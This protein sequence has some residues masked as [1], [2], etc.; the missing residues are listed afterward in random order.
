MGEYILSESLASALG[1]RDARVPLEAHRQDSPLALLRILLRQACHEVRLHRLRHIRFRSRHNDEACRAYEAMEPWE[2]EGVNAR[3]AWANWRTIRRNL[4]RRAPGGPMRAVDLCCGTGQSTEVLAYYLPPGSQI[5]G[6]EYCPRF[7]SVARART[8]LS[9]DGRPADVSFRA[10]S[11]LDTFHDSG[12]AAL[13]DLSIDLVNSSGA[14]G[15]HFDSSATARLAAEIDRVLRP[16]GLALID[17]GR[18]GTPEPELLAIFLGRGF[19]AVH[20]ARSCAFDR[21][22]QVCFRK[23]DAP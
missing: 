12:G 11:V 18:S 15:C 2:F 21:Y 20:R 8:Y 7:V 5:L 14:V 19:S 1:T 23:A 3:Q 22:Q 10:Q 4:D 16:G 17:S 6:L 9:R 13:A